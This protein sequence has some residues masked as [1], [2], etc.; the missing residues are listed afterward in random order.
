MVAEQLRK[1]ILSLELSDGSMLPKQE[2]LLEEFG[3]SVPSLR[4]AMRILETEGFITMVRGSLGGA[5]VHVPQSSD[6]AYTFALVLESRGAKLED[7]IVAMSWLEP[8][9]A[10]ACAMRSDR[11]R[12]VIPRLRTVLAESEAVLDDPVAYSESARKFHAEIVAACNNKTMILVV[13]ALES[14]WTAQVRALRR[15]GSETGTIPERGAREVTLDEHWHIVEAIQQGDASAAESAIRE[16]LTYRTAHRI[17]GDLE[18]PV[19]ASLLRE[20]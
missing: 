20:G 19:R 1:R 13:G 7:V 16:H 17:Y 9:C 15:G 2:E 14:L 12:S 5:V 4:E 10:A 6:A 3:V 11:R 18:M 8:V